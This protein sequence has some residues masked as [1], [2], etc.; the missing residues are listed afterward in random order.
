[1]A[2]LLGK[3]GKAY[4]NSTAL[5]AAVDATAVTGAHAN[6]L[7]NIKDLKVSVSQDTA[8]VTTRASGG[9][10]QSI[11]TLK[12]ATVTFTMVWIPADTGFAAFKTKWLAGTEIAFY[13]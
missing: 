9:W 13:A 4:Y 12:D 2:Y 11:T 10:K 6:E 1:M 8:D 5:T 7:T 3:D